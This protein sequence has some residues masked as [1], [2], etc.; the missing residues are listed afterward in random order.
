MEA[1]G[2]LAITTLDISPKEVKVIIREALMKIQRLGES[3]K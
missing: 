1:A 2:I 3:K